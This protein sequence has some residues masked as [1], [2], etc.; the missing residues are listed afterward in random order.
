MIII[1][2]DKILNRAY[3]KLDSNQKLMYE[4]IIDD[5]IKVVC[6]DAPAGTGKTYISVLASLELMNE[7]KVSKIHYIRFPD[8]R[9]LRLGYLPGDTYDKEHIY[10]HP[11]YSAFTE[12]GLY[13]ESVDD[14]IR[15]EQLVVSTDIS[16]RGTNI[17]NSVVIIDEA[18]NGHLSDLK[19]VLTRVSDDCKVILIGHS[20]QY[21]NFKG[22]NDK[23]FSR[24]IDHFI[25]K[26]WAVKVELTTNYR[27]KVSQWADL[28]E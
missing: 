21:D 1:V 4:S 5:K 9:S 18:Q 25:K 19:L 26:N 28:L 8:D 2:S 16:L 24:Y 10:F 13:S 11:L 12:F 27:G 14:M 22:I 7:G 15:C 23:A 3:H 20:S 17:K 6:V